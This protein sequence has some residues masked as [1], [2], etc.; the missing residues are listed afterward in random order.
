MSKKRPKDQKSKKNKETFIKHEQFKDRNISSLDG[1]ARRGKILKNPFSAISPTPMTPRSWVNECIPNI[2]WACILTAALDRKHYLGLFRKVAINIREKL[3]NHS[4]LFIT[5][6]FISK[7][8]DHEFDTAFQ[9]VLSDERAK[10]ALSALLLVDCLPDRSFWNSRLPAPT[11]DHWQILAKAVGVC[12]DHQSQAATD[13]RWIKLIFLTITG[14]VIFSQKQA[15]FLENLRLYPDRGDMRSVRPMIRAAEIAFRTLEFGEE[16]KVELPAPHQTTFWDE[17]YRKTGCLPR[18]QE[19]TPRRAEK[20]E[21]DELIRVANLTAQHFHETIE[22]TGIDARHDSAFGIV[23]YGLNLLIEASASYCH[24]TAVGRSVLRSI[25]EGFITLSYL[26]SKD[27]PA[28]WL[29]H[30]DYGNGQTKLSLLKNLATSEI[31]HFID[32]ARL[33]SLANEDKWMEFNDINLGAWAAQNLRTVAT[34]ANVKEVYDGYYD[35]CSG[36]THGHWSAIRDAAFTTCF[37]PLHRFHRIP[38]PIDFGMKSI[39]PD[40]ITLINRMLDELSKIYPGLNDRISQASTETASSTIRTNESAPKESNP[41]Q[42]P[43][44]E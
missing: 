13:I 2:L 3:E 15:D 21:T 29:Q 31:P 43:H 4:E 42:T 8:S 32:L 5:H 18:D 17:V 40:G 12:F 44:N 16:G 20:S 35:L 27:D 37:N 23:L 34:E 36:Y 30:R 39:L 24:S 11:D 1:H 14:R 9:D 22:Q 19:G 38:S 28:L 26:V 25:V 41:D 10:S 33:E 6:N 7:F